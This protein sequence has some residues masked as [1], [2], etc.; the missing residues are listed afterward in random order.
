[1]LTFGGLAMIAGA[2]HAFAQNAAPAQQDTAAI[3]DGDIKAYAAVAA[4]V[5]TIQADAKLS[6]ADKQTK[7]AAAVKDSGLDTDKFNA[8]TAASRTDPQVRQKLHDAMTRPP[9]S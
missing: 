9:G 7:M 4:K 5:N 1:M 2:P 6:E 3:S 8:I